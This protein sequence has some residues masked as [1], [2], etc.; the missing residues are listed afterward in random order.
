MIRSLMLALTLAFVSAGS[1]LAQPR[2]STSDAAQT[3]IKRHPEEGRPFVRV[4][5]PLEIGGG[6]QT[7]S[8]LQD[9]RGVLYVGT[10]GAILQFDGASWRRI[11][12]PNGG[13][14]RSLA[15]D[16]RGTIYVGSVGI[17][18][19]LETD[20]AG[21]TKFVALSDHM[22]ADAPQF[23]DVWRT[24]VTNDGVVFQTTV[25]I[26]RWRND[27][28]TTIKPA[29]RFNRA[30]MVD[31]RVYVTTPEAGLTVLEETAVRPLSG[32][33]R[34]KTEPFPV[35]LRYDDRRLLVG[36]R[37]DGL[38]LYDGST[39]IPF[40]T[41]F[42][43]VLKNTSVYR[44]IL[45]P[46]GNVV[47][48]T[49]SAGVVIL[50]RQGHRV[51]AA[52][53]GNG[54]PS[55][56]VYSVMRDREGALWLGFDA[57]LA[58]VEIPSPLSYFGQ[59]DGL[60]ASAQVAERLA[61]RLYV[62]LQSGAVYLSP[63]TDPTLPAHF[64][65]IVGTSGQ[66]WA[67]QRVA[68]QG[69][70]VD[71]AACGEGLFQVEGNRALPIK[72][73][74]DLSF[75][76]NVLLRATA[77]STRLWI[78]LF[79]GLASFRRVAGRWIDEGRVDGIND[80]IRS[81]F[82]NPDGSLWVGTQGQGMLR[83]SFASRPTAEVPRPAVKVE[84]FNEAQGIIAGIAQI[85]PVGKE[86]VIQTGV[87]DPYFVRYEAA[88]NRFVRD[89]TLDGVVGVNSV[90]QPILAGSPDGR[91]F[92]NMGRESALVH[93]GPDEKWIV[94]RATFARL[95]TMPIFGA[96]LDVDGVVWL[97]FGD[98]RLVRFDTSRL[99]DKPVSFPVLVRRVVGPHDALLYGG[100]SAAGNGRRLPAASN[101][102]RFEFAA[103][104]Y[105]DETATEYQSRLEGLDTE[106]SPWSRDA[107][108]DYTNLGFGS[109]R[110][111]VRARSIT[112]TLGEE[113]AYTFAILPPWYRTWWAYAGYLALAALA[114][115]GVA[116]VQRRRVVAKERQ[117]AQFAEARLRAE[118]AEA[119]ARTE[120][121]G[122]KNV[123]L[124]SEIGREITASLDS[125]TIFGK[126]YERLN[127]LAD[128]DVFGVGLYHPDRDEIEYRLAIEKGKRYAPYSRSTTDKNQLPVWCV[129][130]R[131][132]VFIN[133]LESEYSKF[134]T[135]YHEE[136]R[137]LEDGSMS[138]QPQSIIYLPLIAKE[139]VLGIIT[140]QS[141]EKHAYTEH[142]L[143]VM[144]SLA[145]YT[146]IALDN[147]HAY[148]QLNEHEHEIRRLFEEAEKA[149]AIAVEADAAKS[150]FLS[151]VSHELRTPLTSVLGFA[152]IIKKRLEDRIFPLVPTEDKKVT[153][154]IQ[155]VEENLKVVV[156][157]G[158]RL[159]KLID[160]V[161]DLAKIEAGK[162]EW[163]MEG[164]TVGD[165]IDR[166][167]AATASLFEH[168]GLRL[169]KQVA[170]DLPTVTGDRDR[171]IQVVINLIS[172]AVKF[173]DAGAITC[174]AERRAGEVV[175]SVTDTG[176][177]IAPADQ[178]KVFERFKQVGDTLTDKPKGT[179]LGLPICKEIVEHHGG[180]I[181][182]ESAIGRGSTFAFSLPVTPEQ[183]EL[184]PAA[185]APVE[186]AALIR[187]LREQV[188]VT[189]PRTTE[190]KP[191]L[192]VV[193][194]EA[195]IRELLSQELTEAGYDV[196]LASNG[197]DAV[198]QVRR[199]RPDLILLDV[200]MPEM[201]GFDVAAVLKND[202]QTMDI[203]II[204][205]SIVQDRDRGF[206]LGIDRYL[207]KP[208]DTDLLFRE[209][210]T[211]IEQ[212]KSHKRVLVVD[213]DASTVRTLSDVL[214]ARGYSVIEARND[215]FLER[216]VA[217]QPDIIMLS[218]LAS[219][220][221]DAMQM[222]RFEKG[223]ENV[224]FF[225]YQ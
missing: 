218:S 132:P 44:G 15:Q 101:S 183:L 3:A 130:H 150:A 22:P 76:P 156:S 17:F 170:A 138:Q 2:S 71:I 95:G 126:L 174:R 117:R 211:L 59:G 23:K 79:E 21:T 12:L 194:D 169:E 19:R 14:V 190:R 181:W 112:G 68:D 157:E 173:T 111:R 99:A 13:S 187:Q 143:N 180:R 199:E 216:A 151:T 186:L 159:T 33:D 37:V 106:W 26:F 225:V 89:T 214:T 39:L 49:T 122:K 27:T 152:K 210:G 102:L 61:G 144:G 135:R 116:G 32:T 28:I 123:E 80:E 203:P 62:G 217:I 72:A 57:G 11:A 197:R 78:G 209:V 114:F 43:Q 172:N 118:A 51:M 77:D 139:E 196:R 179:G 175:V 60:P 207:T 147:A 142:H 69:P 97:Q 153:Q 66:C 63:S 91:L 195:N 107:R 224:L 109:Y 178:P 137:L 105:I 125:D 148:R 30:S 204:I 127:V 154:T 198:A 200:M 171:L 113:T 88:S 145:A 36:T 92:V 163:H 104:T 184:A 201:N 141:F 191:R 20:A 134:V 119:L 8:L 206:R 74:A 160:D 177:G 75:R 188:I 212:K 34:L 64:E 86:A 67:F 158:E 193:D 213:E 128:A 41:E 94:D 65:S 90:L 40:P 222:L 55:D 164:V 162:L 10:N 83:V 136:S 149:R 87:E 219:A 29:S 9:R 185:G 202:P 81:L 223:M 53:R 120:S 182:V 84:R 18:G 70:P 42:D 45:L 192:L 73:P 110:F 50:D 167:T 98:G 115:T 6:T 205:L 16:D 5:A 221:A 129:E 1:A 161:L 31:G 54:L 131:Q 52:N 108:R 25:A 121:E 220:R 46:S 103:P 35:I 7:W 189:T 47:L 58:R 38:F 133:D 124:L 140:I 165:I 155:Q 208:I 48:T 4:F 85:T 100:D 96:A 176:V 168:K 93:R 215:D 146:A 56:A 82:E 166:A 24:F